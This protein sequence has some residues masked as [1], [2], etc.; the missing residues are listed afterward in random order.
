LERHQHDADPHEDPIQ[1]FTHVGESEFFLHTFKALP[2]VYPSR[3]R[4]RLIGVI[5]TDPY[6]P[7]PVPWMLI[8]IQTPQKVANPTGSG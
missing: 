1:S 5:D 6:P 4:R 8:P 2:L 7:D 3:Q